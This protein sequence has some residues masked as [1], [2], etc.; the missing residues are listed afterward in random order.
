[1][2]TFEVNYN[3]FIASGKVCVMFGMSA[4]RGWVLSSEGPLNKEEQQKS[5]SGKAM[6]VCRR[7]RERPLPWGEN[8]RRDVAVPD[9]SND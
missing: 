2:S 5:I 9:K 3:V 1:M 6:D 7:R 8:L 4:E